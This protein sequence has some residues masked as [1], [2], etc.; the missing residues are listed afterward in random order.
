MHKGVQSSLS[1]MF[2]SAPYDTKALTTPKSPF[3]HALW[4]IVRCLLSVE[5]MLKSA[6]EKNF[7]KSTN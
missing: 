2:R 4:S 5:L 7:K 1:S 6:S 3:A